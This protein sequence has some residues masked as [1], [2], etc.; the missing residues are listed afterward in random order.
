MGAVHCTVECN[1]MQCNVGYGGNAM[2]IE[3]G[4]CRALPMLAFIC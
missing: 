4:Y 2:W 1:V 3:G